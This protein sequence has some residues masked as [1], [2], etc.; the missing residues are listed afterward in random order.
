MRFLEV[1]RGGWGATLLTAPEFV[2]GRLHRVR[3][4]RKAVVV[5]RILGARHLFQSAMSGIR[6]SPEVIAAGTW[7]DGVHALTA[8]GLAA[9]D[10]YRRRAALID[11]A[12]AAVWASLGAHDLVSGSTPPPDRQRRRDQ[13]AGLILPRLPGGQYLWA[14][15]EQSRGQFANS[16]VGA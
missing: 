14:R 16:K 4:D 9:A 11:A 8:F 12:V 5:T 3:V 10:R 7:V 1:L 2:L 15:A 6:P 13:L